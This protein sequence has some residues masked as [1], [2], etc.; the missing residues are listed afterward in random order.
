[1]IEDSLSWIFKHTVADNAVSGAKR[2][3]MLGVFVLSGLLANAYLNDMHVSGESLGARV[4][5]C[6]GVGATLGL[7]RGLATA[8]PLEQDVEGP[9]WIAVRICCALGMMPGDRQP[10]AEGAQKF[11]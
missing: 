6:V 7:L 2:G 9:T 3:A 10:R 11:R 1:M 4:L 5:L 8:R